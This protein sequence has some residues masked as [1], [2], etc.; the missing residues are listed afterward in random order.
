MIAH[1]IPDA[2]KQAIWA[3]EALVWANHENAVL[4]TCL[5]A[6]GKSYGITNSIPSLIKLARERLKAEGK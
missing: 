5:D 4:R 1:V 2:D 3:T 6:I